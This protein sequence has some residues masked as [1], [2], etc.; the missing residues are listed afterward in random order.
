[1]ELNS[2]YNYIQCQVHV[3]EK[4]TRMAQVSIYR[5]QSIYVLLCGDMEH[6]DPVYLNIFGDLTLHTSFS[7]EI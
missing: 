1:M 2:I 3:S 4:L 6:K 5:T 7:L